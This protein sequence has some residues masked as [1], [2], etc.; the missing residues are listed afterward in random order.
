MIKCILE[1]KYTHRTCL[2]KIRI[3][4]YGDSNNIFNKS[5]KIGKIPSQFLRTAKYCRQNFCTLFLALLHYLVIL[6]RTLIFCTTSFWVLKSI[7]F[8]YCPK[9]NHY[10]A[11]DWKLVKNQPNHTELFSSIYYY[12]LNPQKRCNFQC[13][14]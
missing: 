2:Q 8:G 1:L 10:F 11:N 3:L 9:M 13:C 7:T 5:K 12:C 6:L 14:V 4:I